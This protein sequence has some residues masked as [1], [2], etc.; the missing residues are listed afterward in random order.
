MRK[1]ELVRINCAF[2]V[3]F[4]CV[5]RISTHAISVTIINDEKT[6]T[7]PLTWIVNTHSFGCDLGRLG[8]HWVAVAACGSTAAAGAWAVDGV[9]FFGIADC[10]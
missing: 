6:F 10:N 8:A 2:C 3:L 7:I 4:L 1:M 9:G 5:E